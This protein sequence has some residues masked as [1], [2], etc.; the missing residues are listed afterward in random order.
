MV[1]SSGID[2]W[3]PPSP[4][5]ANTSLS[6]RANCAPIAAGSPKPIDPE[7][8]GIEPQPRFVEADELRRPHLMLADVAGD[9][10]LAARETVDLRHQVLRL[11]FVVGGFGDERMLFFPL[12]DLLPPCLRA[13]AFFARH[14]WRQLR[15]NACSASPARA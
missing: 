4:T 12:A 11:D 8:A 13:A 10:R 6:G 15:E 7:T 1:A 14:G 3:K 2:I 5:I 9:N